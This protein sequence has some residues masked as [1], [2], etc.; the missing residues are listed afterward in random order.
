VSPLAHADDPATA[1]AYRCL[2]CG[3]D[4]DASGTD[5]LPACPRCGH[6]QWEAEDAEGGPRPPAP[7]PARTAPLIFA[8]RYVVPAVLVL[9]GLVVLAI[10]PGGLGVDGFGLF[11]G[12]GLSILL[13]NLLFRIGVQGDEERVREE[14]ARE[15]Y[16]RYGRWPDDP[17]RSGGS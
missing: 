6:A 14:R 9:L 1:P 8:I 3:Y 2:N 15:Y 13:L 7:A 10:N 17:R 12:A 4:L 16:A 5:R 11:A